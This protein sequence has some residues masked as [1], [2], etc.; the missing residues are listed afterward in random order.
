[1]EVRFLLCLITVEAVTQLICKAEIFDN[2][3]DCLSS[4][5]KFLDSLLSCPYCVSVWIS[6]MGVAIFYYWEC[7]SWFSYIMV[8]HRLSNVLHDFISLLIQFKI[9]LILRRTK[10]N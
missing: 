1:M 2:L 3:R 9:A 4:R 8:L 7:L 10:E 5:S 6:V